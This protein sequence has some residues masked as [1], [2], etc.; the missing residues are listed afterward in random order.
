MKKILI[1]LALVLVVGAGVVYGVSTHMISPV[2]VHEEFVAFEVPAGA[3]VSAIAKS[4]EESNLIR[5]AQAFEIA[6]KLMKPGYL[7]IG[8]YNISG[9]MSVKEIIDLLA[10]GRAVTIRVTIPEGFNLRQIAE[11]VEEKQVASAEEFLELTNNPPEN[12]LADFPYDIS[13][14]L[15]GFLFPDTYEFVKNAGAEAVI[16]TM[17]H[18]FD[19]RMSELLAMSSELSPEELV[20]LASIVEREAQLAEDRPR[21]A[22]VFLNRLDRGMMLQS[23]A[24]VQ[25]LLPKPKE[26]LTYKDI[27]IESPYNTYIIDGLPPGPI[28]SPGYDALRACVEP[29]G[30]GYLYFVA[31]T[32]GGHVFNYT[33]ENHLKAA[34]S[35]N[36]VSPK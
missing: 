12:M 33:Y 36:S 20:I 15:E 14:N 23:C 34:S 28:C 9:S 13:G 2:G 27:A 5:S 31:T 16:K 29:S 11:V 22:Q 6:Y 25:F 8:E 24:T 1:I 4:L 35:P 17:L 19:R 3:S 26:K 10:S 7:K 30:E 32:S 21:I 18:Q